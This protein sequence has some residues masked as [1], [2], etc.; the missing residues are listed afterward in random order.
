MNRR[1]SRELTMKLLFQMTINKEEI[2][3]VIL[4]L[5]ENIEVENQKLQET[6]AALNNE[7]DP[8]NISLNDIDMEYVLRVLNGIEKNKITI[9]TEIEKYL[10]NW[11]IN[12]ISKI[13]I[14]ILRICT[15]EFLY[16]E[17]IPKNV[18]INE[19]IEL[20]KKYSADKSA[21]FING[22]LGNMLK[23]D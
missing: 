19:A 18:S 16:E 14:T 6:E 2:K 12:R 15:Y 3:D 20:A 8:E 21:A 7:N 22:V 10:L 23:I 5:K 13:D 17:D 4:N 11:K 1:K 9:D